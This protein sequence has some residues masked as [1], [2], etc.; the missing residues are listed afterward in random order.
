MKMLSVVE[1]FMGFY[2]DMDKA[3][4]AA[5]DADSVYDATTTTPA[6]QVVMPPA[7]N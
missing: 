4:V 1:K 2:I 3:P 5:S 7:P 6:S